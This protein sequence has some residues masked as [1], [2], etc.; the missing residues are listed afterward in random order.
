MA[1][2]VA[3]SIYSKMGM[4]PTF[5]ISFGIMFVGCASIFSIQSKILH[6]VELLKLP[7]SVEAGAQVAINGLESVIPYFLLMAKFGI[8]MAFLTTY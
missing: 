6:Q 4:R 8:Q 5:A 3:G 1:T 7:G 2:L